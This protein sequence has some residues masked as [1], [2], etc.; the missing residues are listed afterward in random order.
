MHD[1][2]TGP[3]MLRLDDIR[4]GERLRKPDPAQVSTLAASIAELGLQSPISVV[5]S[6]A[7]PEGIRRECWDLVAGLHRLLACRELGHRTIAAVVVEMEEFDRQLWECDENLARAELSPAARARF[8]ARRKEIYEMKHPESRAGTQRANAMHRKLN[9]N[10][11]AESAPTFAADTAAKTGQAERTIQVDA[12]RGR[13]IAADVLEAIEGSAHD[14]GVVL[15]H[16]AKLKPPEQRRL[17][18]RLSAGKP[19]PSPK[20]RAAS[21]EERQL[22]A[23]RRAWQGANAAVRQRFLTIVNNGET[24]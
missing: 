21:D 8:T 5:A 7:W 9:H 22:M 15:D 16:L 24:P 20:A 12:R 3:V 6:E 13:K 19:L 10:V 2:V 23:L 17:A 14:T 18:T 11:G 4:I 1:R